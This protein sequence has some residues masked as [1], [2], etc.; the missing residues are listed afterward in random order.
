MIGNALAD[1]GVFR[2]QS[3]DAGIV[4]GHAVDDDQFGHF[5]ALPLEHSRQGFLAFG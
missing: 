2:R 3:P 5:D 1:K 4:R